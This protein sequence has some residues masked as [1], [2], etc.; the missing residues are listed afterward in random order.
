M[1]L[2]GRTILITG[3]SAGIGLAFA[4][5]LLELGNEVIVTG[6]RQSVLATVR[7]RPPKPRTT[8]HGVGGGHQGR[9]RDPHALSADR[10]YYGQSGHGNQCL[11]GTRLCPGAGDAS[12]QRDQGGGS[13]LHPVAS[14]PARG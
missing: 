6:R 12:L 14:F 13:L 4:P 7:A 1:K 11:F 5:K 10:H 2:T 8:E 9:R 3:G